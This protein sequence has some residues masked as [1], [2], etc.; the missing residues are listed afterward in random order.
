MTL[1]QQM[2]VELV[3]IVHLFAANVALPRIALAV[4]AL[5]QEVE[6]LVRELD[7]AEQTLQVSLSIQSHQVVL[8]PRRCDHPVG[9][10]GPK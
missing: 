9:S 3:H 1:A 2:R 4:T 8:R 7:A 5:V 10:G 6:R